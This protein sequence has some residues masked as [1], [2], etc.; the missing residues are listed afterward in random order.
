MHQRV[1]E[2]YGIVSQRANTRKA[3][4]RPVVVAQRLVRVPEGQPS[5]QVVR[6]CAHPGAGCVKRFRVWRHPKL[7][8]TGQRRIFK[9]AASLDLHLNL[10]LPDHVRVVRGCPRRVWP[11]LYG[12]EPLKTTHCH[13]VAVSACRRK[14]GRCPCQSFGGPR[15]SIQLGIPAGGVDALHLVYIPCGFSIVLASPAPTYFARPSRRSGAPRSPAGGHPCGT[16]GRTSPEPVLH[17]RFAAR[18][19]GPSPLARRRSVK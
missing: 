13:E 5:S 11:E 6:I 4:P 7:R 12:E 9:P 18:D 15:R 14:S 16:R 2:N 10:G 19:R 8:K 3:R 17:S 1:G